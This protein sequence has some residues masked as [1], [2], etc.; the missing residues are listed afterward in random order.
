MSVLATTFI[1]IP[2]SG[3]NYRNTQFFLYEFFESGIPAKG[4]QSF[5]TTVAIQILS[6]RGIKNVMIGGVL[7]A[8]A[9]VIY[10]LQ[11]SL[12]WDLPTYHLICS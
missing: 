10:L 5:I 9:S 7:A 8:L 1:S 2:L 3:L 6:G 4:A 12:F 11:G